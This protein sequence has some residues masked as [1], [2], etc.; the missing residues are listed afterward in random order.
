MYGGF[1]KTP[2]RPRPWRKDEESTLLTPRVSPFVNGFSASFVP[3]YSPS[4]EVGP[5]PTVYT[6]ALVV[7]GSPDTIPS[8]LTVG[9]LSGRRTP[10]PLSGERRPYQ[11]F[12]QR[13]VPPVSPLPLEESRPSTCDSGPRPVLRVVSTPP[14]AR[15]TH[16]PDLGPKYLCCPSFVS[17]LDLS[18]YRSTR[19]VHPPPWFR[20][21][22]S[23]TTLPCHSFLLQGPGK[24]EH[25]CFFSTDP[26]RGGIV[27]TIVNTSTLVVN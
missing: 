14:P 24:Y 26:V 10:P 20:C 21:H 3:V 15:L 27:Q 25:W 9:V 5:R 1:E 11:N 16:R 23:F 7:N 6:R 17:T 2:R 8:L 19:R 4:A 22:Q 18:K 13:H 12:L